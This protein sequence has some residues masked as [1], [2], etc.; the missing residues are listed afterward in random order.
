MKGLV[1]LAIVAMLLF[2]AYSYGRPWL[3]D[4]FGGV[5]LGPL[6]GAGS[7]EAHCV[8]V[9][10]RATE[11]FGEKIV[12]HGQPPVDISRWS[13]AFKLE[14]GRVMEARQSCDCAGLAC[15]IA[16]EA[17]G[18]LERFMQEVDSGLR[19]NNPPLNFA[20]RQGEILQKL[21][22]ARRRVDA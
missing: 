10:E 11:S 19:Q 14:Q 7:E 6:G 17:L 13:G 12:K 20:R 22:S 18:D 2:V 21:S 9:V 1:K 8:A 4:S 5:G 16:R 3:E 15:E